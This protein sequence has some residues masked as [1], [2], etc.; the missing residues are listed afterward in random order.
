MKKNCVICG[1]G[2]EGRATAKICGDDSCAKSRARWRVSEYRKRNI[3]KVRQAGRDFYK[4]NKDARIAYQKTEKGKKQNILAARKWKAKT[5]KECIRSCVMCDKHFDRIS[6]S[7]STCSNQCSISLG[8]IRSDRSNL[9]TQ[10]GFTPPENLV[11][12]AS[13]LRILRRLL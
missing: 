6:R 13:A 8:K 11:Q 1:V 12:E 9:K 4:K 2:F 10:L 5:R 7:H 3:D